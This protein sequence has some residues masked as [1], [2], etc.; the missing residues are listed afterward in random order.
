MGNCHGRQIACRSCWDSTIASIA[1]D[2]YGCL[3]EP[4]VAVQ[5]NQ[6]PVVLDK[7]DRTLQVGGHHSD[8]AQI[9]DLAM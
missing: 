6:A 1:A 4:V 8:D 7:I 9:H 3:Q 5:D 2:P